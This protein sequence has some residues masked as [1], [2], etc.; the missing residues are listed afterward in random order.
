MEEYLEF[1][2]VIETKKQ[3]EENI[4]EFLKVEVYNLVES[5][6]GGLEYCESPIE[7]LFSIALNSLQ[8][9]DYHYRK[10]YNE[11]DILDIEQQAVI[12]VGESDKEKEYRADFLIELLSEKGLC[13]RFAIECDGYEYHSSKEQFISDRKRDR[14]LLSLGIVTIRWTGKEILNNPTFCARETFKTI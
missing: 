2:F 7:Q 8:F 1:D 6:T 9:N 11:F 5:L 4:K 10:L 12:L 14:D 13:F 3:L